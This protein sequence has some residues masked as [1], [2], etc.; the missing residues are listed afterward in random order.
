[1]AVVI[2]INNVIFDVTFCM[3]ISLFLF[4]ASDSILAFKLIYVYSFGIYIMMLL[5]MFY[6]D[7][8]PFWVSP[9]I[10]IQSGFMCRRLD[11]ATPSI[12]LFSCQLFY[13][14]LAFNYLYKYRS[15]SDK[16]VLYISELFILLLLAVSTFIQMFTGNSYLY[17]CVMTYL[18]TFL[19]LSVI[20]TFDNDIMSICEQAAFIKKTSRAYKFK[21]LF[22]V[23]FLFIIVNIIMSNNDPLWVEEQSWMQNTIRVSSL[24]IQLTV[25]SPYSNSK[26][27]AKL[28]TSK[29]VASPTWATRALSTTRRFCSS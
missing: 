25:P 23:I 1:M 6:A 10:S 20:I 11:Y 7:P 27:T 2:A 5:K 17:Q 9:D 29:R 13:G 21:L 19:F 24:L 15:N 16:K 12:H 18:Y 4:L 3:G 14:Y 22:I 28:K 8:H 26:S